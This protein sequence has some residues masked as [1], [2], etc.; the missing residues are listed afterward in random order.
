[1][2]VQMRFRTDGWHW[3]DLKTHGWT[4]EKMKEIYSEADVAAFEATE[5]ARPGDVWRV[6]WY[7][8]GGDG[9]TAGYAICCPTCGHIHT[10]TTA[11]N[12]GQKTIPVKW[13]D[14]N[15]AEQTTMTCVHS[16]NSS[17]WQWTGSAEENTLTA[18]PSLLVRS[19][20]G[21]HG[22]LQNGVLRSC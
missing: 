4:A 10:W 22:W 19:E 18:H 5:A 3:A 1:M 6:R 8:E 9:P 11:N 12:C 17:C 7:K 16:G 13:T 21:F 20:C 2:S 14:K 15:G